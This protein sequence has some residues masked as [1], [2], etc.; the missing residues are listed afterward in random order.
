MNIQWVVFDLG[1]VVVRVDPSRMS[2]TV[3]RLAG[4]DTARVKSILWEK[5]GADGYDLVSL[6]EQY[7]CGQVDTASFVATV[8]RA[9]ENKVSGEIIRQAWLSILQGEDAAMVDMVRVL[10]SRHAVACL[11]NTN[12]L[13]WQHMCSTYE[14]F[15]YFKARA[16][17]HLLKVEKPHPQAFD[18]TVQ[19]LNTRPSRCLL[20]DDRQDNVEAARAAGWR[21]V[22]FFGPAGLK[23][24]LDALGL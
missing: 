15:N 2:Q 10:S 1:G 17:S 14:S 13:H 8:G 5:G 3:A 21:A 11:S 24:E 19:L 16:A 7:H 9:L 23:G 4:L 12:E 6:S 18:L 20:I 22:R